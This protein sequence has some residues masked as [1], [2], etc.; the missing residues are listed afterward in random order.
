MDLE[1]Q[2]WQALGVGGD[3]ARAFYDGVLDDGVTM[4]LPGGLVITDR[5]EALASMSGAPWD[6]YQL[7]EIAVTTPT[8]DTGLVTYRA[9]ARRGDTAYTA[10]MSTLYLRRA[11]GW[12]LAFHQ[13]TPA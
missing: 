7:D 8:P 9:R 3:E 13:Q 10:L 5:D 11:G 1:H 6:D 4:L 2:G 12:R